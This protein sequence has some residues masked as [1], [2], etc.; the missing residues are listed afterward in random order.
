MFMYEYYHAYLYLLLATYF[1]QN[2]VH[3]S[4]LIFVNAGKGESQGA[5]PSVWN[6]ACTYMYIT[7][8]VYVDCAE[9]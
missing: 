4:I 5:S 3:C 9:G 7:L 6:P 8:T 1:C 2:N